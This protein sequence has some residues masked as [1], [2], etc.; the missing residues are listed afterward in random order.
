[1]VQQQLPLAT[2]HFSAQAKKNTDHTMNKLCPSQEW[3]GQSDQ[4]IIHTVH[5]NRALLPSKP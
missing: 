2:L 4:I 1:M 5:A 3:Q